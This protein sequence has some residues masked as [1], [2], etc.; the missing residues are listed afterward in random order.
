M[1]IATARRHPADRS[2]PARAVIA[3]WGLVAL[4]AS[5]ALAQLGLG[6]RLTATRPAADAPSV[7]LVPAYTIVGPGSGGASPA[8]VPDE[9]FVPMV[10]EIGPGNVSGSAVVEISQDATQSARIIAP[11]A[12]TPDRPSV[13]PIV[14]PMSSRSDTV[15]VGLV[16]QENRSARV[17][18]MDALAEFPDG[19]EQP[20]E[21]LID[22]QVR[23]V[24]VIGEVSF[25]TAL[26]P[27]EQG[28]GTP[29]YGT[30][31][32][33]KFE[34][35]RVP[36]VAMGFDALDALVVRSTVAERLLPAQLGAIRQ[37]VRRGGRLI[38]IADEPGESWS[39][40]FPPGEAPITLDPPTGESPRG[41][42]PFGELRL[43][44][45]RLTAWRPVARTETGRRDGWVL[46]QTQF[47]RDAT[48]QRGLIATGP[49][50]FG[51]VS[52]A[53]FEPR[54]SMTLLDSAMLASI[55]SNLAEPMLMARSGSSE[56]DE[57][58]GSSPRRRRWY[59]PS[60][61]AS[62]AE[63]DA[64]I[65]AAEN[66]IVVPE[67]GNTIF[68]AIA[69]AVLL[70][71]ALVG[72][73]D[74]LVLKKLRARDRSWLTAIAWTALA[75]YAAWMMPRV[76]HTGDTQIGRVGALDLIV[77]GPA[78][79][80][81]ASEGFGS[82]LV[83][84]FAGTPFSSELQGFEPDR[85]WRGVAPIGGR[86]NESLSPITLVST[87][88]SLEPAA[89]LGQGLWTIR[90]L[91]EQ[92]PV[93]SPLHARITRLGSGELSVTITGLEEGDRVRSAMVRLGEGRGHLL[94]LTQWAGTGLRA[95]AAGEA[96]EVSL[97]DATPRVLT[98]LPGALERGGAIDAYLAQG[99]GQPG[100][101]ACVEL[102]I[103]RAT[104]TVT[105][106]RKAVPREIVSVRLLTV[107]EDASG[108]GRR[109]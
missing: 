97:P 10:L 81:D 18:R 25:A 32:A 40:W 51:M 2:A 88:R 20:L 108:S 46:G 91:L 95:I 17:L 102:F 56:E 31:A 24:G 35:E 37:W 4:L 78:G 27:W 87:G 7:R 63:R 67:L 76:V 64:I 34:P 44:P 28:E 16:A 52:V 48:G 89:A 69:G 65:V 72:P 57:P 1:T 23:L 104:P 54:D 82:S 59:A 13:W 12:A 41:P 66:A 5:P 98:T 79:R 45:S 73:I 90:T 94:D 84:V 6:D 11:F 100:E 36:S 60:S 96:G 92:G 106:A 15:R 68:Y 39:R 71:A 107:V 33:A 61:G 70:L 30:F 77:R 103:E 26:G 85:W 47:D 22:P 42:M 109:D 105:L 86:R 74:A 58:G 14:L 53:G 3:M 83:G 99:T 49:V 43:D 80:P 9:R 62:Q 29:P 75:T 93:T 38:V 50:G 8:V 55:W 21:F 19:N 101:W